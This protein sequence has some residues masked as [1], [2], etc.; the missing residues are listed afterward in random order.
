MTRLKPPYQPLR[1]PQIRIDEQNYCY[2][3]GVKVFRYIPERQALQFV[4]RSKLTSEAR[5]TRFVE[6]GIL[7]LLERLIS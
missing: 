2:I 1:L 5:G 3:E 7:D 4:D 6:V